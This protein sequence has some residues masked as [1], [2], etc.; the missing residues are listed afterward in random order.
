MSMLLYSNA[1]DN[2]KNIQWGNPD[3]RWDGLTYGDWKDV[4]AEDLILDVPERVRADNGSWWM[5]VLLVKGEG[6]PIGKP[7]TDI[8]HYRKGEWS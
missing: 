1:E 2:V 3:V 4:R 7:E 8:A 5:D 6:L